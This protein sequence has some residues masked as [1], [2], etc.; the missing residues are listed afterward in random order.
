MSD[1]HPNVPEIEELLGAYALDAVDPDER[2][3]VEAHLAECPRCRAE[4]AG[5]LEVAS[6]M[7]GGGSRAPEGI[8]D[9]IAEAIEEPA[10]AM[11]ITSD[12]LDAARRGRGGAAAPTLPPAPGASVVAGEP[13]GGADVVP[14]A[15]RSRRRAVRVLVAAVGVAAAVILVLGIV[16]ARQERRLD[17]M[18]REVASVDLQR[19]AGQAMAA[20][21]ASKVSLSAPAGGSTTATVVVMPDGNG[22]LLGGTLPTLPADETYQLW[23]IEGDRVISLGVL[24]NAPTVAAFP[25]GGASFTTYALTTEAAGGVA[26]SANSPV[27]IGTV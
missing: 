21:G 12:E 20:P 1:L 15:P 11:R 9:R 26:Q 13:E 5:H 3:L 23:G 18:H 22:F 7:A 4:L 27:A 6:W 8:W 2:R 24:G 25:T 16:V 17:D 19:A 10:P 14:L